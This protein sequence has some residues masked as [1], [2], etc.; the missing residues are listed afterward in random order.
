MFISEFADKKSANNEGACNTVH[1]TDLGVT[2]MKLA[3]KNG[4]KST[5]KL[6]SSF[7]HLNPCH[8]HTFSVILGVKVAGVTRAFILILL[9]V[10][11]P[12]TCVFVVIMNTIFGKKLLLFDEQ[13]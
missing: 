3:T 11:F 1:F 12:T 10:K 8:T 4:Q 5:R 9:Y 13:T 2:K 6:S 7:V